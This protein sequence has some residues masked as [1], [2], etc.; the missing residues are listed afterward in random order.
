MP[1][2]FWKLIEE[3]KTVG[4]ELIDLGR[5]DWDQVGLI[6][7]KEKLGA[8]RRTLQ[9]YRFPNRGSGHNGWKD[10][11]RGVRRMIPVLPN[12]LARVAGGLMYRHMG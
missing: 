11:F 8:S 2:L 4:E 5:S 3:S 12:V 6:V 9:Y 10:N 1:F 7:F